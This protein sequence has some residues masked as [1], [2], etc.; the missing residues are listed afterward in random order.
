MVTNL[1]HTAIWCMTEVA[2]FTFKVISLQNNISILRFAID[3][4][5]C[6]SKYC[7]FSIYLFFLPTPIENKYLNSFIVRSLKKKDCCSKL[8]L[9]FL[10]QQYLAKLIKKG[11]F[12]RT[13][14]NTL[15]SANCTLE[16]QNCVFFFSTTKKETTGHI[17]PQIN[18][19]LLTI[20][21]LVSS[22]LL[23]EEV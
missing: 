4:M 22:I 9:F 15:I 23:K 2:F 6:G 10:E 8:W 5:Y 1:L 7:D 13:T 20:H 21:I 17:S 16:H 14:R 19:L 18:T 3:I 11:I 12:H